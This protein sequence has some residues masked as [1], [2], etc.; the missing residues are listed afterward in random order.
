MPLARTAP[1]LVSLLSGTWPQTHG[2][3]DNYV[4]DTHTRLKVAT[5]PRRLSRAGYR[6][7]A[8]T[9][10]AGADLK[11]L[12]FGYDT[13]DGP[14]DQWNLKYY[15]RQGPKDLRLFLSLF[16]HN[17]FGKTFLPELYYLAGVLRSA[18]I[19]ADGRAR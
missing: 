2:I 12:D 10:W 7:L 8:V 13:V 6:N 1:S 3:R 18:E 5:L 16:T 11:K 14:D 4:A 17:R 19:W 15:I 9:D